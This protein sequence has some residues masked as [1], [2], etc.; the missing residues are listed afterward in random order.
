MTAIKGRRITARTRLRCGELC[1]PDGTL[2]SVVAPD[3]PGS[4][5]DDTTDDASDGTGITIGI[6]ITL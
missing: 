6:G 1:E 3:D 4:S 5:P 2:E